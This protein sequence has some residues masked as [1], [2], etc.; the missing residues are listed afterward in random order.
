MEKLLVLVN[1]LPGS[2]KT[3]LGQAL[4]PTMDAR[5]LQKDAVKEALAGCVAGAADLPTLGGI[6]MDAIWSLVQASSTTAIIDSWWFRPRDLEFARAGIGKARADRVVEVWCDVPADIARARYTNRCRAALHR[7]E[8]RVIRDWHI[9]AERAE[10][11]GLTPTVLVDTTRPVDCSDLARR[12]ERA[13]GR[14]DA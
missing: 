6:A 14:L 7:D 4:A 1:G 8:Q 2:G 3:T 5:F 9:W 10:P 11:L 13:A 12:V